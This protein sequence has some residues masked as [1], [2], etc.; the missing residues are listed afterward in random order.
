M[1]AV[2]D[3]YAISDSDFQDAGLSGE[4]K[5][6]VAAIVDMMKK[7]KLPKL[8]KLPGKAAAGGMPLCNASTA[9]VCLNL[10][11]AAAETDAVVGG[12]R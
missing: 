10:P 8:P 7:I 6:S 5:P 11:E 12:A 2:G 1:E 3:T 9:T 4:S